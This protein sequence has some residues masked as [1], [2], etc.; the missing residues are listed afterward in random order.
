MKMKHRVVK[1]GCLIAGAL[2]S[3]CASY[4]EG[5]TVDIT[6]DLQ[7]PEAVCAVTSKYRPPIT[8]TDAQSRITA[9]KGLGDMTVACTAEG[10]EDKTVIVA[11][12]VSGLGLLSIPLDMGITDLMSG[13]MWTYPN[14][15]AIVLDKIAKP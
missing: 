9:T 3:G 12:R 7:P 13:A 2:L 5:V 11:Q 8:V 10:H 1:W 4:I 6:F 14:R 15:V